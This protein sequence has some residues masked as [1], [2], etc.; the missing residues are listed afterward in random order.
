[1]RIFISFLPLIVHAIEHSF[2]APPGLSGTRLHPF[3]KQ[4][5]GLSYDRD[6]VLHQ[7]HHAKRSLHEKEPSIH[8]EFTT[9]QRKFHLRLKRDSSMFTE[10]FRIETESGFER[11]D[12]SHI[13]SGDLQGD[14]DSFCH[15]SIINGRFEG[16]I[17]TQKGKYYIEPI[18]QY[19]Q[20]ENPVVHSL[21][22]HQDDID[23]SQCQGRG[24]HCLSNSMS[25]ALHHYQQ[26][27]PDN[28]NQIANYLKEVNKLYGSV[29]FEGI[30]HINFQVKDMLIESEYNEANP[31]HIPF[32]SIEKLLQLYSKRNWSNYCLSYLLTDRDFSGDLG[33]AWRGD[34]GSFGGICSKRLNT[35]LVTVKNYGNQLPQ[36]IVHLT[37]AHELGHSLGSFHDK[38][39]QCIPLESSSLTRNN[40]NFL[41]YP[42]ASDGK[43]YNNDK[44]SPCSIK[45]ISKILLAKKDKCFQE[46][47][48]PIC[49]NQLVEEGEECDVG[50]NNADP[51]CNE[52]S[53]KL[54]PGKECS[55]TQ[56]PCCNSQ[57]ELVPSGQSCRNET[58]CALEGYCDGLATICPDS[59]PKAKYTLCNQKMRLCLNGK[60]S[61]SLCAKHNLEQ[62]T[63]DS[64]SIKE[65]CHLWC[66]TPGDP[67]TCFSSTSVFLHQFFNSTL[68][69]LPPGSPCKE[70]Q[71]Y[72]DM[73]H[74]CRLV[75]DDGPIAKLK[76]AIFNPEEFEGISDWMKANLWTILFGILI[77]GALMSST[78]FIFGKRLDSGIAA[79]ETELQ[80]F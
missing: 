77:L 65:E 56:G 15:G 4:Y 57:C 29:N 43:G 79:Q 13:Y 58:E 71:G 64:Q 20:E 18:E 67:L 36:R 6:T 47:G 70:K 34:L 2:V 1:M 39:E 38:T 8:L 41:M 33:V 76:N 30:R 61:E 44:L 9:R 48:Q 49:G 25:A 50:Y 59:L 54:K 80:S 74:V 46:S 37:L 5:E 42:S 75:D 26:T 12:L 35:G 78:V 19:F 24:H 21:I 14:T 55:P 23:Y 17:Q 45:Y 69:P 68:L 66:Q 72:C 73:M 31:L 7:H 60:C 22:Y 32:I 27:L 16:F 62:C 51:C 40:G 53:C 11:A 52:L 28:D 10:N 63:P 3:I